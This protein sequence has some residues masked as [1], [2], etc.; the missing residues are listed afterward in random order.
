MIIVNTSS[1]VWAVAGGS[2]YNDYDVKPV[3][4]VDTN[5]GQDLPLLGYISIPQSVIDD[6]S[7]KVP[8]VLIL[9]VS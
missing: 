5:N 6:E 9:P 1:V 2:L 3:E 8:A 7:E 4:Y